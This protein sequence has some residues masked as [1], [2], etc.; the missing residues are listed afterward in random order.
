MSNLKKDAEKYPIYHVAVILLI[1]LGV[2]CLPIDKLF[3]L[4]IKDQKISLY[5]GG[6]TCDLTVGI[7]AI[8]LIFKY[9]LKKSL[10]KIS[11]KG[12]LII[13]PTVLVLIN[14]FP[15]VSLFAGNVTITS[16]AEKITIYA[17]YCFMT[18]F[19][20]QLIFAGLLYP[21]LTTAY[22]KFRYKKIYALLTTA[23]LFSLS[24]L[25]NLF[26]GANVAQT[27]MQVGYTFLTGAMFTA[28]YLISENIFI[29]VFMH[30]IYDFGGLMLDRTF[31]IGVG[32]YFTRLGII[33]TVVI[34]IGI[35]AY[36]TVVTIR[37]VKEEKIQKG[38]K[39][40]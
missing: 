23:V 30:F 1:A 15:L 29:P 24:H 26:G 10:T 21:L 3:S 34:G 22:N 36:L 9:G 39:N 38:T 12:A 8:I 2:M 27:L 4:F 7:A 18:A 19:S 31:G 32:E 35:G 17:L 11:I 20:E 16:T 33:L 6:I 13:L 37:K 25:I 5:L 14:N 28:A 40:E